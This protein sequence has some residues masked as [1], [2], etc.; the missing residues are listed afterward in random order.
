MSNRL[1]CKLYSY[2]TFQTA[3]TAENNSIMPPMELL[4]E[5][6]IKLTCTNLLH[7]NILRLMKTPPATKHGWG[8]LISTRV[9]RKAADSLPNCGS[10]KSLLKA[11]FPYRNNN[12]RMRTRSRLL[13]H[14]RIQLN[15]VH[16]D[17]TFHSEN[18]FCPP[19]SFCPPNVIIRPDFV[20]LCF[21]RNLQLPRIR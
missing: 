1:T 13:E 20:R 2:M 12:A 11:I 19:V 8:R 4:S 9:W 16:T 10:Y 6:A 3:A 7:G 21:V 15:S 18:P 14:I 5:S 17:H